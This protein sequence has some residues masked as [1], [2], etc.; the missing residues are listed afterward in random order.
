MGTFISGFR[1]YS[2]VCL[3]PGDERLSFLP[4][5]TVNTYQVS[6]H[7]DGVPLGIDGPQEAQQQGV[8]HPLRPMV[9]AV[10]LPATATTKKHSLLP[11]AEGFL[12]NLI[13]SYSFIT[14]IMACC[15]GERSVC[16]AWWVST[17][18]AGGQTCPFQLYGSLWKHMRTIIMTVQDKSV[19]TQQEKREGGNIV[20]EAG[21]WKLKHSWNSGNGFDLMNLNTNV[22][23]TC[24]IFIY[25]FQKRYYIELLALKVESYH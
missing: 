7:S 21:C 4:W 6:P 3:F 19:S 11:D 18:H 8:A 15:R 14:H 23:I 25:I 9:A 2:Q 1:L 12:F 24:G 16:T 10:A 13:N 20:V 22:Y 5:L 17:V